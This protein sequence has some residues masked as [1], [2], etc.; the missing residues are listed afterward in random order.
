[1]APGGIALVLH[2]HLPFVRHP[3][4]PACLEERWLFEAITETYV[5]LLDVLHGLERDA[6]P[7]RL[8]V[9]LSPTLLAMLAD[10]LLRTRYLEHVDALL[11]L[12]EREVRR[13]RG[14]PRWHACAMLYLERF[15][16]TRAHFLDRWRGDLIG[17]FR[18]FRDHGRLELAT[19][20]ATHAILPLLAATPACIRAQIR[21]GAS[22]HHRWFGRPAAGFWLPECAFEPGLDREL[23]DAGVRWV[24][25]DTH[26]LTHASPQPVYGAYAPVA[27]PAGVAAYGRDPESATQVWSAESGYP[28]DPWYRDFHR[29]LGFDLPLEALAPLVFD[30]VRTPTGLKYHRVTGATADKA[31]Y[32]PARARTRVAAHA[33]HFVA[34]RQAQVDRLHTIMERPP[35]VVCPYDAELFG[36]WWFEGMDWLDA[37][38][39]RIA[40]TPGLEAV[41][42]ADDLAR[43]P[44]LQSAAP[45]ASSW[46]WRGHRQVWLGPENEW[47]YPE[48]HAAADALVP[49]CGMTPAPAGPRRRA[50]TQA[51]RELLLAQ[52]SDWAFMLARRTAVPY[53]TRRTV[54]HLAAC[55]RLCDAV[56]RQRIDEADVGGLE[57]RHGLFPTLA[58]EAL[59]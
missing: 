18:R 11:L 46:G 44:V 59:R 39:R 37:V 15:G 9:S 58:P 23:A 6:V 48:L 22:E 35:V 50:L 47:V 57:A 45:A 2:A 7:G 5:P 3:E 4:L 19:T 34:A 12:C 49:L 36:H 1:M 43:H 33:E 54:E 25:L 42:P 10:P 55:R 14:D 31:P 53:A 28:G 27:C 38:L 30:G 52:A 20:A 56:T 16:R 17:A 51:L 26:G 32:D 8:T 21:V 41:T 13:T 40:R 29:D 24:V